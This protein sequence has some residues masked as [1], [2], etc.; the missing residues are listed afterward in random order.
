MI[1]YQISRKG[2]NGR[3]SEENYG[4]EPLTNI[5][6]VVILT[7]DCA[8]SSQWNMELAWGASA[9]ISYMC[10]CVFSMPTPR[11]SRTFSSNAIRKFMK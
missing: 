7:P 8:R 6:K 10:V 4:K 5:E 3:K 2:N 11:S 9:A 1:G